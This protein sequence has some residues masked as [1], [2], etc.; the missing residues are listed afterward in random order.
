[1][2]VQVPLPLHYFETY[3]HNE[4]HIMKEYIYYNYAFDEV[5]SVWARSIEAALAKVRR[6]FGCPGLRVKLLER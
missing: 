3:S 4:V 5:L 1:M 6:E 2:R